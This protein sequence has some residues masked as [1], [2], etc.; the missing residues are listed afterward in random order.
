MQFPEFIAHLKHQ[1]RLSE[2]TVTAYRG[3]LKQFAEYCARVYE[4]KQAG[5][6]NKAMVKSWLTELVTDKGLSASSIRRKLASIRALYQ[7]RQRRGRQQNDPTTN[8]PVPKLPK[9]L[10]T[11]IAET[12]IKHLFDAFP[13]PLENNDFPL[14]RDHV[15]L[16]LLYQ[17]GMR[18]AELINLTVANVDFS[19]GRLSVLGKGGKQR[20]IPI[21]QRLQE[22]LARYSEVREA[23][24]GSELPQLLLTDR[25]KAMYPKYVYNKVTR[26]LGGVST[27]AKRSP[28]VLRHSFATQL[29]EG[30]ADLMA[31][32]ELLGHANLAATQV[33]THNSIT[34]LQ[35]VYRQAHP[36]GGGEEKNKS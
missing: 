21:G 8:I 33:Y 24:P 1:R 9:R 3:D 13:D 11:T 23:H 28:H 22:L 4:V 34:R 35:D 6:V 14:L 20:L 31:V 19:A 15:L 5:E 7:Y 29:L 36:G 30:G 32:K 18:R 12:D 25:G 10:P 2:H 17:T 26:Y 27:E 16:A